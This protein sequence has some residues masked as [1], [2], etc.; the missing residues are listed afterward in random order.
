[1]KLVEKG[2]AVMEML[3]FPASVAAT[4]PDTMVEL[5]LK[6]ALFKAA[7]KPD[8]GVSVK[9]K[10]NIK[11]KEQMRETPLTVAFILKNQYNYICIY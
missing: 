5:V 2:S 7:F 9:Y 1:M 8:A 6:R 3:P 4:S 11:G 10:I